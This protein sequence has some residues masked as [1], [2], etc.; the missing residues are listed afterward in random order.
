MLREV[1]SSVV[2]SA[3]VVCSLSWL[4]SAVRKE[5]F[6]VGF[7]FAQRF[8]FRLFLERNWVLQSRLHELH[9]QIR[10]KIWCEWLLK[11]TKSSN[12][13]RSD[14]F[15]VQTCLQSSETFLESR[16]FCGFQTFCEVQW[17]CGVQT[18]F[19]KVRRVFRRLKML[20]DYFLWAFWSWSFDFGPDSLAAVVFRIWVWFRVLRGRWF[21]GRGGRV[22]N[23]GRKFWGVGMG[24][25]CGVT[26][27]EVKLFGKNPAGSDYWGWRRGCCCAAAFVRFPLKLRHYYLKKTKGLAWNWESWTN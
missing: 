8:R 15:R 5:R 10:L 22:W 18:L 13:R 6:F 16:N 2:T 12:F 26:P 19:C 11:H 17:L 23:W 7:Q 4:E 3:E 27:R 1:P 25:R 9:R 24:Q 21:N 14:I 20:L